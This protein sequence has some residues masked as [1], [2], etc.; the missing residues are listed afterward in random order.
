MTLKSVMAVT[1]RYFTE[2]SKPLFRHITVSICG[3]I[4]AR[5]YCFVLHVRC[6]HKESSRSLS[7][8]LMSLL[9][10][11]LLNVSVAFYWLF[12]EYSKLQSH[13]F[14]G[15]AV[16]CWVLFSV[17]SKRTRTNVVHWRWAPYPL[18]Y[19]PTQFFSDI[20]S[21]WFDLVPQSYKISITFTFQMST[22]RYCHKPDP[23][24]LFSG[25]YLQHKYKQYK[26]C[27]DSADSSI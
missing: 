24:S 4:Y 15:L 6:H 27:T 18:R 16:S 8:L 17:C 2:F 14:N 11:S 22:P 23:T 5:V 3:G 12:W 25:K 7:H 20:P 9:Y 19:G 10:H 26:Y 1:L 13:N 21:A